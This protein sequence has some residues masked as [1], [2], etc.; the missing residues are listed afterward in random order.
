M[1][2][3]RVIILYNK[4]FHYR[5]PIWNELADKCNL[6]VAYSEGDGKIPED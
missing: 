5:I 4:L 3:M 6:T 2:G 1:N